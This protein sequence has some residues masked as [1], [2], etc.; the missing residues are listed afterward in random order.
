M[1]KIL[2]FAT[3][4]LFAFYS[5]KKE[6]PAKSTGNSLPFSTSTV[7]GTG[8]RTEP[9]GVDLAGFRL[10]NM[11]SNEI[12]TTISGTVVFYITTN[13]NFESLGVYNFAYGDGNAT[14]HRGEY[15]VYLEPFTQFGEVRNTYKLTLTPRG[16]SINKVVYALVQI[17]ARENGMYTV[18]IDSGAIECHR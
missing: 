1:R 2:V 12:R 13:G 17:N 8:I 14:V 18:L 3:A 10:L 9:L 15:S 16:V 7:S 6:T 5:C 4:V 11:C